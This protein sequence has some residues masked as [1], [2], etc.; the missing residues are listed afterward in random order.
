LDVAKN[1]NKGKTIVK[2]MDE[3]ENLVAEETLYK[4]KLF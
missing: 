1:Q 4:A 2:Q 3:Y